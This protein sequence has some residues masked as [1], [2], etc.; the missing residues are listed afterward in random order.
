MNGKLGWL[1]KKSRT[2]QKYQSPNLMKKKRRI[3][4]KTWYY[5]NVTDNDKM[6]FMAPS[7]GVG[8]AYSVCKKNVILED[9]KLS[10]RLPLNNIVSGIST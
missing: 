10:S 5:Q 6:Q 4:S 8:P 1:Q 2:K 3:I 7:Y 9:I